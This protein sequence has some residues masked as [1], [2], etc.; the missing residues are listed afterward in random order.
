MAFVSIDNPDGINHHGGNMAW[1]RISSTRVAVLT[2]TKDNKALIQEVN[3]VGGNTVIGMPTFLKQITAAA[4]ANMHMRSFVRVLSADRLLVILPSTFVNLVTAAAST[5]PTI[6]TGATAQPTLAA[7]VGTPNTYTCMTLQRNADGTY[8]MDSSVNIDMTFTANANT[9]DTRCSPI[10]IDISPTQILISQFL[11][12][13]TSGMR[14]V[15]RA[16]LT[17]DAGKITAQSIT[18]GSTLSGNSRYSSVMDSCEKLTPTGEVVRKYMLIDNSLDSAQYYIAGSQGV[19]SQILCENAL[20]IAYDA[21]FPANPWTTTLGY[22]ISTAAWLPID[23]TAKTYV[24][25]GGTNRYGNG[26]Q[27]NTLNN[28]WVDGGE[29]ITY[30]LDAAWVTNSLACIVGQAGAPNTKGNPSQGPYLWLTGDMAYAQ[31][32]DFFVTPGGYGSVVRQLCMSFRNIQN[33]GVYVGPFDAVRTQY[34]TLDGKNSGN[35]IHRLDDTAFWLIGC[36]RDGI[37]GDDKLGVI[38]VK[39]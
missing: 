34:Y 12:T 33:N 6:Y 36:F 4:Q 19:A 24:Y 21:S 1:C 27:P 31:H 30:P 14:T 32:P 38:T 3:Y 8:T 26:I 16:T 18:Q 28:T 29:E 9:R 23:K 5:S 17:L 22:A 10:D 35:M 15:K 11:R 2:F 25:V 37:D 39:A 7:A 13:V 20:S